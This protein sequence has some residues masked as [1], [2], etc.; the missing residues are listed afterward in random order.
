MQ[1]VTGL[2]VESAERVV[3]EPKSQGMAGKCLEGY[4]AE[5]AVCEHFG[6]HFELERKAGKEEEDSAMQWG[7]H[8]QVLESKLNMNNW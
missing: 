6:K 3:R 2:H 4:S 7:V 5:Q 1:D 8:W